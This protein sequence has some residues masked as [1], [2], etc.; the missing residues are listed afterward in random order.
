MGRPGLSVAMATS[1]PWYLPSSAYS[2]WQAAQPVARML[3]LSALGLVHRWQDVHSLRSRSK[4]SLP[5]SLKVGSGASRATAPGGRG[6]P[7]G[8]RTPGVVTS[9]AIEKFTS[10]RVGCSPFGNNVPLCVPERCAMMEDFTLA[11]ML[12]WQL[13]QVCS[14][15]RRSLGFAH[16]PACALAGSAAVASPRWHCVHVSAFLGCASS[17]PRWHVEHWSSF[18]PAQA[19]AGTSTAPPSRPTRSAPRRMLAGP[20]HR[21]LTPRAGDVGDLRATAPGSCDAHGIDRLAFD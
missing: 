21:D 14:T 16:M 17:I 3:P 1:P 20:R 7:L 11:A 9:G 6:W 19:S 12:L 5:L 15:M 4:N 8:R 13:P 2:M 10:S 18:G